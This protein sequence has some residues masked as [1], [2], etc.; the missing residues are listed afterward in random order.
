MDDESKE[1]VDSEVNKVTM[2]DL[3]KHSRDFTLEESRK[4]K[5]DPKAFDELCN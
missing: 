2:D 4:E 1:V 3:E 5:F